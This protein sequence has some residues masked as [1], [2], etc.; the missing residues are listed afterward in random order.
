[1][2]LWQSEGDD[3][4]DTLEWVAA[5]PWCTGAIGTFGAS[6]LAEVQ[7]ALA[8][9]RPTQLKAMAPAM[10]A[11]TQSWIRQV[12]VMLEPI[13][14]AYGAGM[15][16]DLLLR[17]LPTGEADLDDLVTA[18]AVVHDPAGACEHL[19]VSDHPV[20]KLPGV[21]SY[22]DLERAKSS[23]FSATQGRGER[24][25]AVPAFLTTGW[26][27]SQQGGA[28]MF[29]LL[30]HVG[31]TAAVRDQ[32]RLLIGPW[33]HNHTGDFVG[34]WG[35]TMLGSPAGALVPQAHADFFRRHL[36]GDTAAAELPRVRYFVMG[37]NTWRTADDW[38]LPGTDVR[39][40]YLRSNGGANS[41]RGDGRLSWDAPSAGERTDRYSYDPHDPVP[42]VGGRAMYTGGSTLAGPYN[43]TRIERRDDVLVYTSDALDSP[44]EVVGQVI[45]RL[46]IASSAVDTDFVVKLCDVAPD[47]VSVNVADGM[48][49]AS[50]LASV[51][52]PERLVAGEVYEIEVDLAATGHQFRAGHAIRLSVTSSGFPLWQRNMN[53]GGDPALV[54]RGV[55]AHQ[56]VFHDA[57]RP[58]HV[59][60]PVQ[61]S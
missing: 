25:I 52:G 28:E 22:E 19:P 42:S 38:P 44:V 14:M 13:N 46:W 51:G 26:F 27:D 34:E 29:R 40:M 5:Q 50:W 21:R 37:A 11:F 48:L 32:S 15:A 10:H 59:A 8:A 45:A 49:R 1:M 43:Q 39:P 55:V 2:D 58:S 61:P 33:T 4:E 41:E 12:C 47:G 57:A 9:R 24:D 7:Y 3:G 31:S 35:N 17:R 30:R 36:L 53:T 18:M 16:L 23:I 54:A 6:Y 20:F 56:T 60:L